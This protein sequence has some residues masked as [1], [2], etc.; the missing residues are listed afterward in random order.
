MLTYDLDWR[1][2]FPVGDRQ[3]IIWG[4]GYRLMQ[5]DTPTDSPNVGFVPQKRNMQLFSAFLQDEIDVVPDELAL[6]LGT[7]LEH[8]DFSG[9]EVQPNARLAW[10]MTNRQTVWA[11]VSRAIRSPSR[12]DVDYRIPKDPPHAVSGRPDFEAEKVVAYEIGYR[13]QPAETLTLSLA[14]FYN[15]YDDLYSVEPEDPSD[16]TPVFTIQN[17][18]NGH[19]W[20]RS[21]RERI[22]RSTGGESAAAIPTS[23]KTCGGNRATTFLPTFSRISAT[24]RKIKSSCSR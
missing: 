3:D 5:D 4:A 9:F 2:R 10:T 8:N 14:T 21:Y 19:S 20:G 17:G 7:K 22:N 11:A 16:P 18:T 15:D 6:T 1:H 24:I 12:I 13:G 23:R